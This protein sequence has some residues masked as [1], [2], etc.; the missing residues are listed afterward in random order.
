MKLYCL[1]YLHRLHTCPCW[2]MLDTS[3]GNAIVA[4]G[5]GLLAVRESREVGVNQLK[6][7]MYKYYLQKCTL[8]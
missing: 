2:L 6:K 7:K 4:N 1:F 8:I 3:S 5:A